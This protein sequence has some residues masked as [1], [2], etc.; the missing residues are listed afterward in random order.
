VPDPHFP[1]RLL[2]L[3]LDGT[4]IGPDLRLWP[5]T[6][7]AILA[8]VEGGVHVSLAT[9]RMPTSAQPFAAELGLHDPV[10]AYQGALVR[11]APPA[12]RRLGRLIYHRPLPAEVAR[13]T[14][15]WT[16]ERGFAPHLNH[17]E[18]FIIPDGDPRTDDYSAFLGA[19]AE[20]VPDLERWIRRPVS[21]VLAV[22]PTG[23][24]LAF[25]EAARV[26]FAGRAEV[27]VSHPEFLEF[28]APGVSKGQAVR[29]LARRLRIPLEQTLAIGDQYNDLE[30]IAAAGHGVAMPSAPPAV[31]GAARYI[32]APL[33]DEGAAEVIEL[34]VLAGHRAPGN[35]GRLEPGGAANVQAGLLLHPGAASR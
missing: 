2:A 16:R 6:R 32:A 25:L 19:Q 21:K 29:W 30:M 12:D 3:D 27:T 4:L 14:I 15:R 35:V 34:L 23:A 8:A 22:G 17:L 24:P 9:G 20:I 18:R 26:H 1:I 11:A 28:L 13:E 10:I 7:A 31:Q 33:A 5:R